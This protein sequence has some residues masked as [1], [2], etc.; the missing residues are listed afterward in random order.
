[1]STS[2]GII[3]LPQRSSEFFGSAQRTRR[4]GENEIRSTFTE[5]DLSKIITLTTN[6]ST[7]AAIPLLVTSG[8]QERA[9]ALQT[10]HAEGFGWSDLG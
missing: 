3:P 10:F 2:I 8:Q 1:M 9:D 5:E 7:A 4:F 6:V